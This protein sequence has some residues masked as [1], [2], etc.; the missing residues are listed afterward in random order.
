VHGY[1]EDEI[2]QSEYLKEINLDFGVEEKLQLKL[3]CKK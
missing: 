1:E 2:L 3:I